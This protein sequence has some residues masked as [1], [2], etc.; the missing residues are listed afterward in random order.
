M[1]EKIMDMFEHGEMINQQEAERRRKRDEDYEAYKKAGRIWGQMPR[2]WLKRITIPRLDKA[3][4]E[5]YKKYPDLTSTISDI[6]DSY[7]ILGTVSASHLKPLIPGKRI[8]GQALTIRNIPERKTPTQG[9]IDKSFIKMSTRDIYP[10]GEPGDVL[11]T[12]F[13]GNLDVS[14]MGGMS[15]KIAKERGFSGSIA[16][17]V[18]RDADMIR[19]MDYPVWSCGTTPKTGKFRLQAIEMNGPVVVHDILVMPGDLIAADGSGVCAIPF[20]LAESVL[21][22]LVEISN[23]EDIMREMIADKRSMDEL[24]PLVRKRYK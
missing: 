14:N 20:E 21:K 3:I 9:Y 15:C 5:E 11:V 23:S 24:R 13:R 12:D 7:G 2:E 17:G 10:I 1:E 6:L 4:I 22:K 8:V 19:D 18:V 16:Y